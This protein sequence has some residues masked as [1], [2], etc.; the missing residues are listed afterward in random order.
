MRVPVL[1]LAAFSAVFA[2][3]C[4]VDSAP[5]AAE[6]D[7][8]DAEQDLT[9]SISIA[10]GATKDL[11][12]ASARGGDVAITIDCH[13]PEN[14]DEI[15]TTFKVS[16]A[17]LSIAAGDLAHAGLWARSGAVPAGGAMI[18]IQNLGAAA[19]CSVKTTPVAAATACRAWTA[20]RSPNPNHDHLKVGTEAI[21]AGWE[22]FPASGN[23][24]GAWAMWNTVYPKAIK[25]GY[26]LHNLEH[27]GLVLSYKCAAETD[28]AACAAARDQLVGLAQKLGTQRLLITPDPTQP[29]MFA[30]RA[31]RTSYTSDCF[32]EK[33]ALDFG[34]AHFGH[35][36][37]DID[38]N[39]PIP[40]DP[41][42]TG[43]PCQDLMAAPD[44]C[45]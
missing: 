27:G 23:H 11:R 18:S 16:S 13:P 26:L 41:T 42:G 31:W 17:A 21:Q 10:A 29:T 25:R 43:V 15:G 6:P 22:P 30:V 34:K 33:S 19:T 36:R 8:I 14:P 5:D 28:S 9:S 20:R 7:S 35:G 4:T 38:A 45:N 12:L 32:D 1:V 39:P 44:S 37:E 2:M 40:F 3:A 24:W